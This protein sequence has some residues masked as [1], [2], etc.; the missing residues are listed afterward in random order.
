MKKIYMINILLSMT[1]GV[2]A[3]AMDLVVDCQTPGWLSSKIN[4]GDQQTVRNLK[5]TGYINNTD[6]NFI[7]SLFGKH[8]LKVLD[9]S[10]AN[11]TGKKDNYWDGRMGGY[12]AYGY[13]SIQ[14]MILPKSLREMGEPAWLKIDSLIIDTKIN[15][16][17]NMQSLEFEYLYLGESVDSIDS[18]AFANSTIHALYFPPSLKY[19][20]SEAF[21]N[22]TFKDM[23][24]I[25]KHAFPNLEE[26]GTCAF[27]NR[28]NSNKEE[29]PDTLLF[30]K[31]KKYSFNAF[32]YKEGM[33]IFLGKDV[34]EVIY[35]TTSYNIWN[36]SVYNAT[37]HIASHT[38]PATP[39]YPVWNNGLTIYVPK[40]AIE[41]YKEKYSGWTNATILPEATPLEQIIL[42]RHEIAIEVNEECQLN[43]T[44]IPENAD[45][46]T[47]L[48]ESDNEQV[49]VIN[50]TGLIT[51]ISA[52]ISNIIA[53]SIDGLISDTCK[54]TVIQPVMGVAISQEEYTFNKVGDAFQLTATIMPEDASNKEVRWS[55]SNENVCVVNNG[56][57]TAVAPGTATITVTTLDGNF[58]A[59]CIV[60]VVQHVT[61]VALNKSELSLKVN[62]MEQLSATVSPDNAENKAITWSSSDEQ[63]AFVDENGNVTTLKDGEAWIKVVSVDNPEAKDSC[64]VRVI[65]PVTGVSL[66]EGKYTF[67]NVGE[68]I[69]LTA[70]I[71][72]D[73]ASN[74]ELRWS[75]SNENVCV[76]S[77]GLVTAVAPGTATVTVT[78]VDGN[79]TA[80][81]I[82]KVIQHVI[83]VVLNK[84]ELSLKP[85]ETEQLSAMVSPDNAEN[86][87]IMW[88]SSDEKIAIVDANGKIT[89]LKAGEAWIKAI[90]QDNPEAK[91][92]CKV[93]VV[94]PVTGITLSQTNCKMTSIGE[95]VQ[96]EAYVQPTDA[97]NK[98]V[99]WTSTNE[100]VCVVGNGL[101]ISTGYGTS[102]VLASTI[103]GGFIAS[104]VVTVKDMT[105]IHYVEVD[106]QE[107]SHIYDLTGRKVVKPEKGKLYIRN[108]KVFMVK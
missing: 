25:S 65:Q 27:V 71:A 55:S 72:P 66:S 24:F 17:N 20:G 36:P 21:Y 95:S 101:V 33:H 74:K 78:T 104:C 73:D 6:M 86:K 26:I 29:L 44:P 93:T 58:T 81:C 22:V 97:T 100:A 19:I 23:S 7:G 94:Q 89:A 45:D 62:E 52:G 28:D 49:A 37:F 10:D 90:S 92:S 35:Q 4:Y 96:L 57:V 53:K 51:A 85:G 107:D 48:W 18:Y 70:T 11:M 42:D 67:E 31:I 69:Q 77:N 43:A 3:Q 12:E 79:F 91:D 87:A 16:I 34:E 105:A 38:P 76:V 8:S 63:I 47:I 64:M 99:K 75:C 83:K 84:S 5:V 13:I 39:S 103:D 80:S 2:Y 46:T 60:K 30:P 14:K 50:E 9:L 98:E 61:K 108:R 32:D 40:D 59:N 15:K 68:T 54:V 56:L 1:L 106:N 41:A 102:V 82:V 88:S